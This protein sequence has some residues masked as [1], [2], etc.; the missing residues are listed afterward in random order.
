MAVCALCNKT[1]TGMNRTSG[2]DV[3]DVCRRGGVEAAT[4]GRGW[5]FTSRSRTVRTK[6]STWYIVDVEGRM[7]RPVPLKAT[8]RMKRGLY[9]LL[10]WVLGARTGDPL[11][12][13]LVYATGTPVDVLSDFLEDDGAQSAV[14]DLVGEMGTIRLQGNRTSVSVQS[15]E[16]PPDASRIEAEVAVLMAHLERCFAG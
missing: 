14:M 11:F 13:K 9:A 1:R 5:S 2:L 4:A 10:G 7:G 8:F 6:N 3:C 12:D 15:T 16:A